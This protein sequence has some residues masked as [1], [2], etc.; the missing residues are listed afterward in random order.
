MLQEIID[1]QDEAVSKLLEYALKQKEST[2][3][4]PTGSGKTYI[5]SD[6]MNRILSRDEFE[7]K[8]LDSAFASDGASVN[9]YERKITELERVYQAVSKKTPYCFWIPIKQKDNRWVIKCY[10]NGTD[11]FKG[12]AFSESEVRAEVEKRLV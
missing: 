5:M 2:F 4:A 12:E 3:K 9:D 1:L 6:L 11:G 8:S 7:V 10:T